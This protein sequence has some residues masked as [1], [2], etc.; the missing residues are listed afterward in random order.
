MKTYALYFIVG[1]L[2]IGCQSGNSKEKLA[3]EI[4]TLE[5]EIAGNTQAA[6]EKLEMLLAKYEAYVEAFPGD[7]ES[8][9]NYLHKAA[10]TAHLLNRIDQAMGCYERILGS[11]PDHPRASHALFMKG[12]TYENDL[13]NLDS[14]SV[15]YKQFIQKYPN[16]DFADDAQFLLNNIGK[17]EEEI[18]KQFQAQ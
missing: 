9:V 5:E 7:A 11:Y 16:D 1:A 8:N 15:I 12:F 17:S 10:K 4:G 6:P 2:L 3:A 14:A 13:K 18:I